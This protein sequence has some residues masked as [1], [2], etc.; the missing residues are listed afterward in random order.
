M[1]IERKRSGDPEA[2]RTG[3]EIVLDVEQIRAA[4]AADA[5]RPR[6]EV[7]ITT[8]ERQIREG[9]IVPGAALPTEPDL[10]TLL[11]TSRTTIRHALDELARRGLVTRRRGIGTFVA[12]PAVE[13][14]L[15]RLSS[16][17]QTLSSQRGDSIPRLLGVR[18]TANPTAAAFLIDAPDGVVF[19]LSRLFSVDGEPFALEHIYLPD[20]IGEQLPIDRLSAAV[21]DDL[22][23]EITGIAVNRG[24]ETLELAKLDRE[25]AALFGARRGDPVFLLTR[26]VFAGEQPVQMRRIWIRGDRVRFH[27]NLE[28]SALTPA[29]GSGMMTPNDG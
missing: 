26:M 7:L 11:G 28:G 24:H 14:P 13:Q 9:E 27:I 16:F 29:E 22:I 15:G 18:L 25:Q 5:R 1:T 10:A 3:E 12:A 23:R 19:E 2:R 6:Y 4:L 21:I 8:L 17:I 20:E